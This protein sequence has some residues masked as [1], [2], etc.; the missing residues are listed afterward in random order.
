[1]EH[2][3]TVS[4]RYVVRSHLNAG[5]GTRWVARSRVA[6]VF[7]TAGR[8]ETEFA[9][10][11]GLGRVA[12][13]PGRVVWYPARR[14]RRTRA[15]PPE[16]ADCIAAL[17]SFTVF[18]GVDL[19]D[20]FLELPLLLP[21]EPGLRIGTALGELADL[22][23]QDAGPLLGPVRR[24]ELC[25]R[26]LGEVLALAPL[27]P[28]A[29]RRLAGLPRLQPVLEYIDQHFADG[30]RIPDL[31]ASVGLSRVQFHRCFRTLTGTTPYE[32]VKRLRLRRA[33]QLLLDSDMTVAEIGAQVGWVD[34]FHFSKMFKAFYGQ[35]PSS[36]RQNADLV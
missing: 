15:I 8:M 14:Q 35:A 16:G 2:E 30:L 26:I 36:Y 34:P 17:V 31:A 12:R 32:Y 33:S 10:G 11:S 19:F 6:L 1:M 5:M 23:E 20:D 27:R 7:T 29:V 13:G 3:I 25:Y 4:C 9:A 24:K 22:A 21:E 18:P 28:S